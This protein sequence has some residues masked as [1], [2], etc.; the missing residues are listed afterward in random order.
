MCGWDS[1]LKSVLVRA[2]AHTHTQRM[3]VTWYTY[4][5]EKTTLEVDFLLLPC[6]F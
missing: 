1:T 2:H 3:D 5:G 6:G 4:G